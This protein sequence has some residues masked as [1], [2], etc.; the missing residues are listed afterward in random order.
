MP[1]FDDITTKI[2]SPHFVP[3]T[4]VWWHA[5]K[6]RLKFR[7]WPITEINSMLCCLFV[8]KT[9]RVDTWEYQY[10]RLT[11]ISDDACMR[12]QA[13]S[14]STHTHTHTHTHTLVNLR[15]INKQV[16]SVAPQNCQQTFW[17]SHSVKLKQ[18]QYFHFLN[19]WMATRNWLD[20]PLT[21]VVLQ[22]VISAT[23]KE[24]KAK[25]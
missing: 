10:L 25:R 21:V 16:S 5:V 15:S 6:D 24:E 1:S 14:L 20:N 23:H 17:R 13:Y 7:L 9:S 18:P 3:N 11:Y 8:S 12:Q 4:L 22:N 2:N 19:R